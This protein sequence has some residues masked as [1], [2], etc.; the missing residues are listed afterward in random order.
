MSEKRDSPRTARSLFVFV[1]SFLTIGLLALVAML[2]GTPLVFP[3]LGPTAFMLFHDPQAEASS[4]RHTILGHAI[5]IVCGFAA[6][7]MTG[8]ANAPPTM[9]E[10]LNLARVLCAV[11]ALASTGLLMSAAKLW[12]PPAGATTLIV[13]LGFI[14]QPYHLLVMEA[15]VVALVVMAMGINRFAV[16]R[17]GQPE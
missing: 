14:T 5:G 17:H 2:S 11:I 4:P 3:S 8:L 13:A 15:A 7:W 6:L 16:G 1:T 10:H 12:H 9:T